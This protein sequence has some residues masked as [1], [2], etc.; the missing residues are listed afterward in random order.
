MTALDDRPQPPSRPLATTRWEWHEFNAD[1]WEHLYS[2]AE[3]TDTRVEL[4]LP[5]CLLRA[6]YPLEHDRQSIDPAPLPVPHHVHSG[7]CPA[8]AAHRLAQIPHPRTGTD[9]DG[10]FSGDLVEVVTRVG[11]T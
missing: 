1:G 9:L 3:L 7:V 8:C 5:W 11:R 10:R 6:P 4:L 2:V